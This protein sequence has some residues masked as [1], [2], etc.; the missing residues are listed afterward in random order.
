MLLLG[1]GALGAAA[2]AGVPRVGRGRPRGDPP[3]VVVGAGIAGLLAAYR[4]R[5]A[6]IAVQVIEAQERT[7]GRVRTLRDR[8][9]E[10][11]HAELGAEFIDTRHLTLRR[12]AAELGLPL[13]DL[14]AEDRGLAPMT[15]HF[16]GEVR[17]E[18]ELVDELRPLA[19]RVAAD[20]A[21]LP[22]GAS[23]QSLL[24]PASIALDR[25][26]LSEWL[27]RAGAGG[28]LRDLLTVAY[29][30]EFGLDADRQSAL[31]FLMTI[32]P[33]IPPLRLYG[34]SDERFRVR[35]GN[36]RL[37]GALAAR[38]DGAVET[39]AVLEAVRHR[40]DG[41][42]VV[43]ARRSAAASRD[44][45]ATHVVLATP[46]TTL[47]RVEIDVPLSPLKRRSIA[48]LGYGTNAKLLL[49]V[50]RRVW[51]EDHRAGG[52]VLTDRPLQCAWDATR[53][54][55][56]R[57]G[58]LT[59]FTGGAAGVSMGEGSPAARAA[60]AAGDLEAIFPGVAAAR[61]GQGEARFHW[62]SHPWSLGSYACHGPGQ[63]T[64]FGE[65]VGQPAGRLH[66]AG[67]HCSLGAQGFMEGACQ[68]AE[69]AARAIAAELARQIPPFTGTTLP[70][71]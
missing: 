9:P 43:T 32:D 13:D 28:W 20:L 34:D 67:E 27:E 8:F 14:P 71:M 38:L 65:V 40:S 24:H 22:S 30:T 53:C 11:Q 51:R 26:S 7:G 39:G 49:A 17:R 25:F 31:N 5:Q 60:Q 4:L 23:S 52:M 36:D 66:F 57:G 35:G 48:E 50:S 12:L 55:P 29:V 63:W 16:R 54:Q 1:A 70:V 18:A 64:A 37:C 59:N 44:I 3:V 42:L 6:G 41:A 19:A 62:P 46:F 69:R 61:A 33:R 45:A 21:T 68:T 47:R 10:R 2:C 56:G 58:V 15:W